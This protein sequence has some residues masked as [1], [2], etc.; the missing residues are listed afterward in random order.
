MMELNISMVDYEV[1]K[2]QKGKRLL[3]FGRYAGI[4]GAYNG[5]LTYGLKSGKYN[6]KGAH[7]CEDRAE[8]EGEMSKIKL[9]NEKI[10][11]TGNGRVGSGILEIIL[12]ANIREVSEI[13]ITKQYF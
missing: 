12:K 2:N 6:L 3:G 10:I 4:V 11:I 8:M 1:L 9:S 5:F 7:N 13:R